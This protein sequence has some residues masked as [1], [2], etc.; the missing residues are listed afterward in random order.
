MNMF[1]CQGID[2]S[3]MGV[4]IHLAEQASEL[5]ICTLKGDHQK[6]FQWQK[7]R[8]RRMEARRMGLH[9]KSVTIE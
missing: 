6:N 8:I 2:L 9:K 7:G 4:L 5:S 3:L 1:R